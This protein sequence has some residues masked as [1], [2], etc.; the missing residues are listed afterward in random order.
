[1]E[2]AVQKQ[3]SSKGVTSGL[4]HPRKFGDRSINWGKIN[5]LKEWVAER[6]NKTPFGTCMPPKCDWK[7]VNT[8]YGMVQIGSPLSFHLNPVGFATNIITNISELSMSSY[9]TNESPKLLLSFVSEEHDV[10]PKDWV[11]TENERAFVPTIQVTEENWY[12][13]E[14]E[15]VKQSLCALRKNRKSQLISS[16]AHRFFK[17]KH[18]FQTLTESFLNSNLESDLPAA[19]KDASRHGRIYEPV[20]REKYLD[21]M[22]FHLNRKFDV[23]ETGLV[24]QPKLF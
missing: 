12:V 15:T 5:I 22:K 23:R 16:I 7:K 21:V 17:R 18:N 19:N 1:M 10:F 3:P 11:L 8:R 4:Y 20:A 6:N 13:L 9:T 14:Q 2:T 24:L